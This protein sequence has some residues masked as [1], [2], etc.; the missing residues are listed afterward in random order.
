MASQALAAVKAAAVTTVVSLPKGETP[1][2]LEPT[3][4]NA[5]SLPKG[6]APILPQNVFGAP[7]ELNAWR[8]SLHDDDRLGTDQGSDYSTV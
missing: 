5:V 3:N 1:V 7:A 6:E 8:R 4:D 2:P